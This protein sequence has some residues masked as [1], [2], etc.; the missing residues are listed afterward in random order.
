SLAGLFG[1]NSSAFNSLG[2]LDTNALTSLLGS[3]TGT[4]SGSTSG[5]T[6]SN[7]P[8]NITPQALALLQQFGID[9]NQLFSSGGSGSSTSTGTGGTQKSSTGTMQTATTQPTTTDHH[10]KFIVRWAD[11]VLSTTFTGIVVGMQTPD[12]ISLLAR[13]LRPILR[14]ETTN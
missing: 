10:P 11:A 4:T 12:F 2:G 3:M 6:N 7:I 8:S 1:L 9:P 13:N 5:G 14:P